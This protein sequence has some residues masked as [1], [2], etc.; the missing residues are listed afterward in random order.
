VETPPEDRRRS[1]WARARRGALRHDALV[2]AATIGVIAALVKIAWPRFTWFGD[3]AESFFP[4][5]HIVGSALREGRWLGF[6]PT[7]F[8]GGN[9]VGEAN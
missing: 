5:W 4:L 3:N 9:I 1:W 8:G 7:G 6:D 2:L